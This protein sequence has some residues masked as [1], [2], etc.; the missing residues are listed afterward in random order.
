MVHTFKFSFLSCVML[1]LSTKKI[2]HAH[3]EMHVGAVGVKEIGAYFSKMIVS[4][5]P[6]FTLK[7][8]V[9]SN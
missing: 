5:A 9:R 4:F 7:N 1:N 2:C 3:K 6:F 8:L